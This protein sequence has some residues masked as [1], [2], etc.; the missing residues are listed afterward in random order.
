MG[1]GLQKNGID[2]PS[3]VCAN[4]YNIQ[5]RMQYAN[6]INR[7]WSSGSTLTTTT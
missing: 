1:R 2:V 7:K 4:H 5:I 3:L 6:S